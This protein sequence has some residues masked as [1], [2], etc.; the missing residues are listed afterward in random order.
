MNIIKYE[1]PENQLSQFGSASTGKPVIFLAGP[2]VRGHQ[3]HL[4]SWRRE[5]EN[6]F[7][8][9][10]FDGAIIVPEFE[11]KTESDQYRFDIPE[12]EF[13]GLQMADVILFWVARTRELI[14][15]T[16]NF[17]LGYWMG[18]ERDKIVYGR[19]ED[20]YRITYG[21]IMW[22]ADHVNRQPEIGTVASL[23]DDTIYNTLGGT[24]EAAIELAQK[25]I[26]IN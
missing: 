19:P 25:R 23:H 12:W 2:T 5:A 10:K 20:A 16:T 21:D 4:T 15:L 14:A 22:K 6:L 17:E 26:W 7:K 8:E 24:V 11:S 9:Y 3:T 1:T 13:A 18:R